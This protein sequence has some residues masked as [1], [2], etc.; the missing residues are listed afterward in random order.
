MKRSRDVRRHP[1]SPAVAVAASPRISRTPPALASFLAARRSQP[2]GIPSGTKAEAVV[3]RGDRGQADRHLRRGVGSQEGRE[4]V[5]KRPSARHR[6]QRWR[7]VDLRGRTAAGRARQLTGAPSQSPTH[8]GHCR[9]ALGT[10]TGELPM[11]T[12]QQALRDGLPTPE[13]MF[14]G[15]TPRG[16]TWRCH[17]DCRTSSVAN[18]PARLRS[19]RFFQVC[20]SIIR[21]TSRSSRN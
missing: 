6:C 15:D 21:D 11:C 17:S 1:I 20:R 8:P 2:T 10:I 14:R 16:R 3:R 4:G 5:R 19:G 7:G 9:S 13:G 18:S 12:R